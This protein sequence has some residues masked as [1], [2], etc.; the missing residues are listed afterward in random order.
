MKW[1]ASIVLASILFTGCAKTN[2]V[3]TVREDGWTRTTK[4]T[5]SK[6][7]GSEDM[8]PEETFQIPSGPEWKVSKKET[9]TDVIFT[10]TRNLKLEQTVSGDLTVYDKGKKPLIVNSVKVT[11]LEDGRIEY[12]ETIEWKGKPAKELQKDA[13]FA[14]FIKKSGLPEKYATDPRME[15]L[16]VAVAQDLW[17]MLFGPGDPLLGLFLFHIDLA[18]KR[19][20]RGISSSMNKHLTAIFGDEIDEATR[21]Q[22]V[23]SVLTEFDTETLMNKSG[24]EEPSASEN[25]ANGPVAMLIA[26]KLPGKIVESNGEIDEFTGEVFWGLYPEAAAIGKL[27]LRAI[28]QP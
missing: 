23:G 10:A 20:K 19:L 8:K 26:V 13:L 11:K 4:Y 22:I 14:D 12:I 3:S 24:E 9:E 15:K 17:K 28:C 16:V 1:A 27:E 5:L 6:S 18:E 2:T 7:G 25:N 21:K